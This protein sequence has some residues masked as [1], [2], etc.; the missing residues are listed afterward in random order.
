MYVNVTEPGPS[1]GIVIGT[2]GAGGWRLGTGDS[3]GGVP[4]IGVLF[5][6][7][8]GTPGPQQSGSQQDHRE[9]A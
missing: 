8:P 2:G 5:D 3:S 4:L 7:Q 9:Q 6:I 1:Q